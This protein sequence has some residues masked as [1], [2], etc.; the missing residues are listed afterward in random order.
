MRQVLITFLLL[1][2]I[3][4][5]SVS[6]A[7]NLGKIGQVYPI[8]EMDIV[9]LIHLRLKQMEQS[10]ELAKINQRMLYKAKQR[11]DRPLPVPDITPAKKYRTW[12]ID[13]SITFDQDIKDTEGKLIVKAGTVIN[14]FMR[15]SFKKALVFY[16]GDNK[17]QAAWAL[18][19]DQ[20]LQGKNKMILVNGSVS[21]QSNLLKKR[22]YFDQHGRLTT[23]FKIQHTPAIVMQAGLK[24]KVEE[25]VP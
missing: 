13:P 19:K 7:K 22:I 25:L 17:K 3:M 11:A 21:E 1:M 5:S 24:L 4:T 6:F 18:K 10:G 2:F 14:P 16:D 15:I 9:D 8:K 12:L 23:K 20:E